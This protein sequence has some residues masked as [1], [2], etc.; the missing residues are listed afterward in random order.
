[1][2]TFGEEIS[3]RGSSLV[4][5]HIFTENDESGKLYEERS[6]IFHS[7]NSSLLY[8]MKRARKDTELL[9]YFMSTDVS[10]SDEYGWK[11]PK[12]SLVWVNIT[13]EDKRAIGS[14]KVS[15]VFTWIYA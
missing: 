12:K 10:K 2:K 6:D 13:K 3:G 9:V 11:N 15:E 8:L 5:H 7:V 14:R 1:M 4:Q